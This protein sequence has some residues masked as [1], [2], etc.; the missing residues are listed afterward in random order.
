MLTPRRASA[1]LR[2][3]RVLLQRRNP[4]PADPAKYEREIAKRGGV[5]YREYVG[6]A[7]EEVG[8]LQFAFLCSAGLRPDHVLVDIG[9][10]SLRGGVHF[11]R[12]LDAGNYLGIEREAQLVEVGIESELGRDDH[13]VKQPEFVISGAF[14]FERFSK[15]PDYGLALS[16]FTH[17]TLDDIALCLRK[18]RPVVGPEFR[19]FA[20]FF[21]VER[22]A[23][24]TGG[25]HP[26]RGFAY[27]QN[28]MRGTAAD[29]GWDLHYIG[30]WGHPRGQRMLELTPSAG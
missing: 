22:E 8:E 15:R 20:S 19:L 23:R 28:Q 13:D 11:I 10:G 30:E 7:W 4:L 26:H 5:W 2:R 3:A 24:N 9:C 25:S 18:L 21:E 29:A 12:Y 14:E 27:T 17:L 6:G 1:L 16:V